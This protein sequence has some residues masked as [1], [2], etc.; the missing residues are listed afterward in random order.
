MAYKLGRG[1]SVTA[2]QDILSQFNKMCQVYVLCSKANQHFHCEEDSC[3]TKVS[4]TYCDK[5][6]RRRHYNKQHPHLIKNNGRPSAG[7]SSSALQSSQLVIPV[8]I[9]VIQHDME[10]VVD[11]VELQVNEQEPA[12]G[13]HIAALPDMQVPFQV[14]YL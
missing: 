14:S 1:P 12:Q 4:T 8:I 2:Q 13:I 7:R 5:A 6:G 11:V 9:P 3:P 10:P